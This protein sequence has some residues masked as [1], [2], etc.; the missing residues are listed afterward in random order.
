M[1]K[2]EEV[3][4]VAELVPGDYEG[5]P[6]FREAIFGVRSLSDLKAV[7]RNDDYDPHVHLIILLTITFFVGAFFY[8]M[9]W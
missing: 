3:I 8:G 7:V 6:R 9:G 1:A 2:K 5:S 4:E